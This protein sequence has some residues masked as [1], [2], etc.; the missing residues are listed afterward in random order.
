MVIMQF[1]SDL[2]H[3]RLEGRSSRTSRLVRKINM[4]REMFPVASVAVSLYNMFPMYIVLV[5]G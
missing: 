4:P 3:G 5:I 2:P 1:F